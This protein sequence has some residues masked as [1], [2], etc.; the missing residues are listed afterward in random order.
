MVSFT[1]RGTQPGLLNVILVAVTGDSRHLL[2]FEEI[3]MLE[4]DGLLGGVV[5]C[6]IMFIDRLVDKM[7]RILG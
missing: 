3:Q 1:P 7:S 6:K 5:S 4:A 2:N